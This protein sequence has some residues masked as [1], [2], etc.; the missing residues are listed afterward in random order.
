LEKRVGIFGGSFDPVHNGHIQ[1]AKSFLNSGLIQTL[2]IILSPSPPHKTEKSQSDYSH[3][4]KMLK[5]AFKDMPDIEVSDLESILPKPSY[6][7]QTIEYL[8]E[9]Y[10]EKL[11]YLCMGE[12]SLRDFHEWYHY[13]EIL[14][15][16]NLLVAS[17][18]NIESSGVDPEILEQVIFVDHDPVD[19]SSTKIRQSEKNEMEHLPEPVDR[20][21]KKHNLYC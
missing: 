14:Q 3:R 4:F 20:Y 9:N 18:P 2:L 7:V 6:T 8:K 11:F 16:V 5:L 15:L 17:R 1:I 13:K 10:P 19:V 21:I 12:D